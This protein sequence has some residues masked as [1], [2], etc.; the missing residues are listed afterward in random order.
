[1]DAHLIQGPVFN[2]RGRLRARV[3]MIDRVE[4][5]TDKYLAIYTK[6]EGY[7]ETV[8]GVER[9]GEQD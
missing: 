2:E 1:M 8:I 5:G 4:G 9:A 6:A 7:V 3:T